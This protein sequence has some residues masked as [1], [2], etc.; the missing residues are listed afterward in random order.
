MEVSGQL[1][2]PASLPPGK[3]P[4]PV[5]IEQEAGW[6]P[7]PI[8]TLWRWEKS[9]PCLEWKPGRPARSLSLYRLSYPDSS[10]SSCTKKKWVQ[11]NFKT[12]K[13]NFKCTSKQSPFTTPASEDGPTGPK[14]LRWLY[15][16]NVLVKVCYN[17]WLSCPL[18][19]DHISL[20]RQYTPITRTLS[21]ILLFENTDMW[22]NILF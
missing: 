14:Y 12:L 18:T 13:Y 9:F 3:Y 8:W 4:P 6:A 1:H 2:A 16:L 11:Y 20:V 17:W 7:E 22:Q 10:D 5:P 19:I 15:W 21:N